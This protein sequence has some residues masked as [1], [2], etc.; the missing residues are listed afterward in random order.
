MRSKDIAIKV[1]NIAKRYRIGMKKQIHDS[2]GSA[3]I[4]F[5]KSP[6]KNYHKYRSLYKFD[7][8]I[9]GQDQ[10][11]HNGPSDTIW[12]LRD[13][14]FDVKQG[15]ALGII[16]KNGAGKSTLLKILSKITDP[17]SGRAEICGR[18]SSLLE[19]GTGFH[20]E[21]TGRENVYLN[22]TILGMAKKEID[23]KFD[24]IVAFSEVEKFID[25]PVKRYSTGMKVRL[26]FSVAAH[27][28][29]EILMVDE[30]LA[31]GDMAF[32]KKCLGKMDNVVSKGRT[33]LFVSH[34]MGVIRQ[35]CPM[36]L[37][38]DN[39]EIKEMG[40]SDEVIDSYLKS[41][42]ASS[43]KSENIFDEDPEKD[44][45]L[46][47]ARLIDEKGNLTEDF[48][49]DKPVI[50]ELVCQVNRS[51][52]GLK[53]YL[54]I[55][56]RDG[57]D[58]MVSDSYDVVPNPLDNLPLGMHLVRITIP[59]RTLGPGEYTVLFNFTSR[60]S[61]KNFDVDSPGKVCSFRL[62]DFSSHRGNRRRGFF[63]TLLSWQLV[64][65]DLKYSSR[66]IGTYASS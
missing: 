18:V 25:T 11:Q 52:P 45:Q 46:R 23:R 60:L 51:L 63:S 26:A 7:D 66:R 50:I 57:T 5:L 39:G 24:E 28:E 29:Q 14:T 17:T 3:I 61:R 6:I 31:V 10:N 53:G 35:L 33:V 34:N 32:Q 8:V 49:C 58:V 4:D 12:A 36:C 47:I 65:L 43:G 2:I 20:P 42:T 22:G 1:E 37:L 30:V 62:S 38:L 13:V 21:L 48:D 9:N 19:V 54:L 56:R 44:F 59:A 27:L 64:E 41:I 55:S 40:A 15:E 16:G